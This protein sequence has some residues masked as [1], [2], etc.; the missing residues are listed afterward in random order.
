MIINATGHR[1]NKLGNAYDVHH[2]TN[3]EI[4]RRM[5]AF[6]LKQA[7]FNEATKTFSYKNEVTLISGMAL[8]VD[9]IWALVALKLKRDFPGKFKLECAIPCKG[10]AKNWLEGSKITYENILKLADT[11]TFVSNEEYQPYL[12]QKRNEYMV[13]KADIVFAVWDG[14]KGGT[15]NCVNYAKEKKK[16]I[17][18]LHPFELTEGFLPQSA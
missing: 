18:R 6:I 8:G 15:G 4:G 11:V 16:P 17:Y 14:T 3:I 12:M 5:R 9:T 7:G 1:P 2:P 13:D 10:H